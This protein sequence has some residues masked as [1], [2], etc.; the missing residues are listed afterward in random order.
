MTRRNQSHRR[1]SYGRRQHE[2]RE[3]QPDSSPEAGWLRDEIF[4]DAERRQPGET[5]D[6]T[7]YSSFGDGYGTFAP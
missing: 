3:R 4:D 6:E 5:A 7:A 2:V 1:R